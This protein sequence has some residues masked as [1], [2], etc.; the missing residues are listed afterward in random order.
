MSKYR[1]SVTNL[2]SRQ[3]GIVESDSFVDAVSA[4]GK[5]MTLRKGDVL[6]IGVYGFPPARFECVGELGE[7]EPVWFPAGQLAA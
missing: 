6:E 7:G 2:Q 4:L 5:H 1:F 3:E